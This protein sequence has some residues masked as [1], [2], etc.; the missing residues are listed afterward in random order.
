MLKEKEGIS[1]DRG[2]SKALENRFP[3]LLEIQAALFDEFFRFKHERGRIPERRDE[4]SS[5][6]LDSRLPVCPAPC[7]L[8]KAP[9]P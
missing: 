1:Y 5:R 6:E 9:E 7:S 3:S 2:S 8:G 4:V